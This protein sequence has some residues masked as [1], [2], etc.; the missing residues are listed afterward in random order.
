V[1]ALGILDPCHACS[2]M[3]PQNVPDPG[4]ED[5]DLQQRR[6]ILLHVCTIVLPGVRNTGYC[7]VYRNYKSQFTSIVRASPSL[8]GQPDPGLLTGQLSRNGRKSDSLVS[9]LGPLGQLYCRSL[10]PLGQVERTESVML[11]L[12]LM[13]MH[14]DAM[15]C[16]AAALAWKAGPSEIQPLYPCMKYSYVRTLRVKARYSVLLLQG[17]LLLLY[18]TTVH[19]S[20]IPQ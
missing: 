11:M 2:M 8:V 16:G 1:V 10:D 18:I 14:C 12:M 20:L 13:L 5:V 17:T 19:Y 15:R 4:D 6:G 9:A 7:T 3:H